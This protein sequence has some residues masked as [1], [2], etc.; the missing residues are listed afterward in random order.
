[1]NARKRLFAALS[2]QSTDHVPV[3]LLFPYHHLGCYVDVRTHS[4]YRPVFEMSKQRAIMLNRRSLTPPLFTADVTHRKED[5]DEDGWR[6]TRNWTEYKGRGIYSENRTR[7]GETRVKRLVND[8]AELDFYT[9]LPVE[10]SK[11]RIEA[12]L[13]RL[14]PAYLKEKSEFPEE[15]GSMMLSLGEP[16]VGLYFAANL[17]EYSMWSI[18]HH[19]QIVDLFDRVMEQKRIVYDYCLDRNLADVYFLVGSELASPP[20]VS[21]QTFQKWIVPYARELIE[22]VHRHGCKVIQH[23]HGQI[24]QI[25][26]DF[27]TM[28]PDGLHVIESPP[29]GDC[30]MTEAFEVLQDRITLI[31]N[32]QYDEFRSLSEEGMADAVRALLDECRGHPFILSPSAGPFDENPPD[33][34]IRNYLAFLETAWEYGKPWTVSRSSTEA[35]AII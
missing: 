3:W 10:T 33:R 18:T 32:I 26:P 2:Q 21:R 31:G 8:N 34:F 4:A 1:M 15:Y 22:Q 7:G 6:I 12:S 29:I 28:N 27:L 11:A 14:L 19:D 13:D 17:E 35:G 9:S 25:L 5:F 20:L 30:T 16:V 24:H 23:Y